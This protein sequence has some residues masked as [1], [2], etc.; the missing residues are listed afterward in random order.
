MSSQSEAEN[1]L[2]NFLQILFKQHQSDSADFES[3]RFSL[4]LNRKFDERMDRYLTKVQSSVSWKNT[5]QSVLTALACISV[6]LVWMKLRSL[7][8][9]FLI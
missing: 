1:Q 8:K 4:A 9:K 2:R 6:V 7:R 3:D 5:V